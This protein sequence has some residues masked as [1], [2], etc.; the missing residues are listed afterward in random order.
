MTDF[1]DHAG[2]LERTEANAGASFWRRARRCVAVDAC[3]APAASYPVLGDWT[4]G[5]CCARALSIV[6]FLDESYYTG[7]LAQCQTPHR[8]YGAGTAGVHGRRDDSTKAVVIANLKCA[9]IGTL[10]SRSEAARPSAFRLTRRLR[11][12]EA[13]PSCRTAT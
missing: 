3:I 13:R 1:F 9:M 7:A 6:N 8:G 10:L 11:P 2:V 12:G 5:T 4:A